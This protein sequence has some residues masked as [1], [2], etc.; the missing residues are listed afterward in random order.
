MV[1]ILL[2]EDVLFEIHKGQCLDE[3][4]APFVHQVFQYVE[5]YLER[6][7]DTVDCLLSAHQE[8]LSLENSFL[9]PEWFHCNDS[10]DLAAHIAVIR[11]F[12]S[13]MTFRDCSIMLYL[14]TQHSVKRMEKKKTYPTLKTYLSPLRGDISLLY[15][16]TVVDLDPKPPSRLVHYAQQ[17]QQILSTFLEAIKDKS[18]SCQCS[19]IN[20]SQI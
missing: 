20:S 3:W 18:F 11:R 7:E 15:A 19:C 1:H 13:A 8:G 17:H 2:Q 12:L 10:G 4:G 6:T 16:V 14:T 9:P 5:A